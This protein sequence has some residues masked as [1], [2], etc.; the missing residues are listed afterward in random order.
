MLFENEID[1]IG[2]VK[3]DIRV[4]ISGRYRPATW[5]DPAEFPDIEL[6]VS[7]IMVNGELPSPEAAAAIEDYLTNDPDIYRQA[8]EQAQ[9]ARIEAMYEAQERRDEERMYARARERALNF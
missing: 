7:G 9:Q 4:S 2:Y 1:N 5:L 8:V 6:E 3:A